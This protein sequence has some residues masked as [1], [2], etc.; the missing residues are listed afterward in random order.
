MEIAL[1]KEGNLIKEG[2][3]SMIY[4][5]T[6]YLDSPQIDSMSLFLFLNPIKTGEAS[7]MKTFWEIF[8]KK[9]VGLLWSTFEAIIRP[10]TLKDENVYKQ[11][12]GMLCKNRVIV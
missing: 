5:K 6:M 3:L 8:K 10:N 4:T 1:I 7:F 11:I 2:K 9:D 12:K